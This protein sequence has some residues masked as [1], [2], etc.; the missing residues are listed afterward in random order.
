MFRSLTAGQNNCTCTDT[1][2]RPGTHAERD[3]LGA[4]VILSD[5]VFSRAEA[6]PLEFGS[7]AGR[8]RSLELYGG[9]YVVLRRGKQI[10]QPHM[11]GNDEVTI[12]TWPLFT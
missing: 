7:A 11:C 2:T 1:H 3:T 4:G 10:H 8:L 9:N 12:W 6:S 5:N